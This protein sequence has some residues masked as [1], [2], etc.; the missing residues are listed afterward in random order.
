MADINRYKDNLIMNLTFEYALMIVEFSDEL[1]ERKRYVL[2][3]Q[4]LR[5][6]CS[7]GA[8]VREAQNAESKPDFIHKMKGAAKEADE[9][10]F[11]LMLCKFSKNYPF[12]EELMGK[13]ESIMK[14]LNKIISS[15]K[16]K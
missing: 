12:R 10:E 13:L 4:I 11:W 8:H 15:S 16:R 14:V 6:G 1:R 2:A 3:D 7:I 5:S 9:N